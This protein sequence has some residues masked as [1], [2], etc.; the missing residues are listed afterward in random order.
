MRLCRRIC[1][2][3]PRDRPRRRSPDDPG[4]AGPSPDRADRRRPAGADG[5]ALP[6]PRS[7]PDARTG[8]GPGGSG[9][10]STRIMPDLGRDRAIAPRAQSGHARPPVPRSAADSNGDSNSSSHRLTEV[11]GRRAAYPLENRRLI[12]AASTLRP[13]G[14]RAGPGGECRAPGRRGG[15]WPVSGNLR[16]CCGALQSARTGRRLLVRTGAESTY[17]IGSRVPSMAAW[18]TSVRRRLWLRA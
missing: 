18:A 11:G 6:S 5:P 1:I 12:L 8:A 17:A 7:R 3:M 16:W 13:P 10:S 4:T 15:G 9:P 14:T 2:A